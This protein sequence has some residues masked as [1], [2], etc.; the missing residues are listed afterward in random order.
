MRRCGGAH[1]TSSKQPNKKEPWQKE[2]TGE[3]KIPIAHRKVRERSPS[4]VRA[5]RQPVRIHGGSV[6]P[7]H[8]SV[9]TRV[10]L[11]HAVPSAAPTPLL[12]PRPR[13]R[14]RVYP[15]NLLRNLARSREQTENQGKSCRCGG[16]RRARLSGAYGRH[17]LDQTL[18][19]ACARPPL[20]AG[21]FWCACHCCT[22]L[23]S[24]R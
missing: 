22:R 19:S 11:R 12:P 8:N 18:Q 5:G 10:R 14:L 24:W 6:K 7:A 16:L 23:A 9:L 17:G 3:S 13:C 4:P 2:W 15:C 20:L 21:D 1:A